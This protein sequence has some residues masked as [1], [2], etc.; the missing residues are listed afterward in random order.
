[1]SGSGRCIALDGRALTGRFTGDRTYWRCLI[2]ALARQ[3]PGLTFRVYTRN[4]PPTRDLPDLPNLSVHVLPAA[5]ERL[6]TALTFPLAA[7]RDGADLLHVQYTIPPPRLAQR[8]IVTTVHD[9]SFRLFPEWFPRRHRALLNATVPP[10]MRRA[11]RVITD[12]ESSRQDI[13]RAYR[14]ADDRV[15]AIP[16]GVPEEFLA[17]RLAA[18]RDDPGRG[19]SRRYV[20]EKYGLDREFILAVGV[21]QPRKNLHTLADAFG[22]AYSDG[23]RPLLAFIGKSGW[24][25]QQ[26]AL[27]A[28]A[29]RSGGAAAASAIRFTGYVPDEDLP[30]LYRACA[31]FV[32]PALYEGFGI[33]PLEALACG[34]PTV[35]SDAPAMPEVVGEAA[36]IVPA[37]D[38]AAWAAALLRVLKE[39][40]LVRRLAECGPLRAERFSWEKTAR[41]TAAVYREALSG[42]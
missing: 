21:L 37:R 9:I 1:M 22:R 8:P 34:A 39:P 23:G 30:Q 19:R 5:S 35:V 16:L 14:L 26:E 13:L 15:V 2:P 6:W 4:P 12:S 32:H 25:T 38:V 20:R 42:D 27:R 7:R 3:E 33:P 29:A 28:A 18:E 41:H 10:S 11:A 36:L 24:G 17:H 31:V 40:D